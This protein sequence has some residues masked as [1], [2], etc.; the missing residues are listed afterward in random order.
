MIHLNEE[1][2][3]VTTT[4]LKVAEVFGKE[5]KHVL[6]VLHKLADE[7]DENHESN[8]RLM[9]R[10]IQIGSGATRNSPYYELTR[11]GFTRLVM[12]FSGSKASKVKDRFN[13]AFYVMEAR[14]R[15]QAQVGD[16]KVPKTFSEALMLAAQQQK[17]RDK[18]KEMLLDAAL[19][20]FINSA[21]YAGGKKKH[22]YSSH[23]KYSVMTSGKQ[24][25]FQ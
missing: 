2:Q 14:I 13:D 25:R 10:Q 23:K 7:D 16:F 12:E 17:A 1:T 19:K 4:S 24:Q 5:H 21:K 8:F 3:Q 20:T 9:V 15:E 18:H 22:R 6:T 11:K